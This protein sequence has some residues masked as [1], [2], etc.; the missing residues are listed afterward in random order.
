MDHAA[1]EVFTTALRR[2]K[3]RTGTL[4]RKLRYQR[5]L[6]YERLGKRAQARRELELVYAEDSGFE[7]VAQRLGV[8]HA[9]T[10][11]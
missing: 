9:G 3:G 6:V 4:L 11:L 1:Q 7:D 2:S 8:H 10:T 5:A